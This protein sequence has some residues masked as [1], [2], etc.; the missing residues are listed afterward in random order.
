MD[1]QYLVVGLTA[2]LFSYSLEKPNEVPTIK[3]NVDIHTN[4]GQHTHKSV[5]LI[6]GEVLES[7]EENEGIG[8]IYELQNYVI[9]ISDINSIFT[10]DHI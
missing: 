9:I 5:E 7:S 6:G 1:M 10:L 3:L 2:L 4:D 8:K